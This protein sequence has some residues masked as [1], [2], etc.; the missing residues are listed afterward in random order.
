MTDLARLT[1]QSFEPALGQVFRL[2]AEDAGGLELELIQVKPLGVA[3]A[4]Y[5]GRQ[6][7]SLLFRGPLEPLLEQQLIALENPLLGELALFL[8]PVG[9]DAD[10]MLYDSTFN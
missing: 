10:G 7:F 1:I 8:V 3:G 4:E 9:A 2:L 6:P 5:A